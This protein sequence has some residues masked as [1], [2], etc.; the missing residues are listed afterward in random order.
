VSVGSFRFKN[1]LILTLHPARRPK[2]LAAD[3]VEQLAQR[4]G[5]GE[6]DLVPKVTL[7]VGVGTLL[8]AKEVRI[9]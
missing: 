4:W 9:P 3:T 2:T 8:A 6:R 7:T 5:V 1:L